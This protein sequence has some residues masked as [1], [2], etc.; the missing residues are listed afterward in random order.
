[1]TQPDVVIIGSGMGGATLAAALAPTS[2]HILILERNT[3]LQASNTDRDP[4]AIFELGQCRPD[5]IWIDGHG[6]PFNPGNYYY[7]MSGMLCRGEFEI[8]R[9]PP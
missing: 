8:L 6:Q 7:V 3:Y 4:V 5:E 2:R 1:M 9:G